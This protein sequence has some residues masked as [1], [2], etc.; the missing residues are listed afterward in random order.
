M[1]VALAVAVLVGGGVLL[2]LRRGMLRIIV[3]FLLLSHGANLL[4]LAAG[5]A[6]RRVAPLEAGPD[7]AVTADPLPQAFVLTA[8]VI[9]FA[10]TVYM[11][12][13]AVVG[14]EDDDTD[15]PLEGRVDEAP[16]LVDAN[17]PVVDE[18]ELRYL[19]PTDAEEYRRRLR[20][21]RGHLEK[22]HGWS[23]EDW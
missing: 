16:D 4:L 12:V 23:E 1:A 11:L 13:L 20:S 2:I 9:A 19:D 5:G 6:S 8:I 17:E 18:A 3:G 21:G 7:P 10:I 15:I 22:S 14:E